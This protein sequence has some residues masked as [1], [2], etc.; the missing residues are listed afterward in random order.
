MVN[1]SI[2]PIMYPHPYPDPPQTH[3]RDAVYREEEDASFTKMND[4]I[5][6]LLW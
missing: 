4:D 6:T 2:Y 1:I 5:A 3:E